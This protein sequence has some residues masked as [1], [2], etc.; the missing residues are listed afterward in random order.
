MSDSAPGHGRTLRVL[1]TGGTIAGTAPSDAPT[2]RYTAAQ[3]EVE[4]LVLPLLHAMRLQFGG[5][6]PAIEAVQVAQIDSRS[7]T[8]AVWRAL[9]T[10][11]ERGLARQEVVGQVVSHGTDTV[12][13]TAVFLS[14]VL[15][16]WRPVVLTAAMRPATSP[17]ADGPA[18]LLQALALA[19]DARA[20]GVLMAFGGQAWRAHAVR[21][22]HPF[23]LEAFSGGDAQPLAH[24]RDGRWAWSDAPEP[25]CPAAFD[26]LG[27]AQSLPQD[28]QQWPVVEIVHSHAGAADRVLQALLALNRPDGRP[29]VDGVVVSATGNGSLHDEIHQGLLRAVERGRLSRSQVLVAS[30]CIDGSIVGEPEQG[31]RIAAHLTPA[32]ARVALMLEL[33][34]L[35]PAQIPSIAVSR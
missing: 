13:E 7:M 21:K 12:E 18:N 17:Q 26:P 4:H 11:L 9:Q 6:L 32:Q 28:L 14:A 16:P 27:P 22:V 35:S 20:R 3:L 19:A 30:R 29:A 10:E 24:W 33:S 31:W 5:D 15:R 25:G 34:A 2:N 23:R 1:G 8:H